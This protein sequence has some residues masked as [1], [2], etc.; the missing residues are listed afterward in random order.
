MQSAKYPE[1]EEILLD[2]SFTRA[3]NLYMSL[4]PATRRST[5]RT[6]IA[7]RNRQWCWLTVNIIVYC[8]VLYLVPGRGDVGSPA[9]LFSLLVHVSSIVIFWTFIIGFTIS[10]SF[11][12]LRVKHLRA[13]SN[14]EVSEVSD[15]Q[16]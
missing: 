14:D 11:I 5:M 13:L 6:L 7:E 12:T 4:D 15:V 2:D 8:L 10:S 1:C 16:K 3:K 9:W